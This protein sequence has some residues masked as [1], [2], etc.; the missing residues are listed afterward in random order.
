VAVAVLHG[1]GGEE[2]LP[3]GELPPVLHL[4]PSY[5]CLLVF[6]TDCNCLSSRSSS[7]SVTNYWL[8]PL[9]AWC[10]NEGSAHPWEADG[11]LTQP[12][13]IKEATFRYRQIRIRDEKSFLRDKTEIF[14]P[15]PTAA[16]LKTDEIQSCLNARQI[17]AGN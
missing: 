14:Q 16:A 9:L 17:H 1:E 10:A 11:F 4:R 3:H 7:C 13:H 12:R 6:Y 5:C 2:G 15:N 8:L